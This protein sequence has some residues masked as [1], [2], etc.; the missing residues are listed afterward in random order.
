MY[1]LIE[2]VFYLFLFERLNPP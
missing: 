2:C 1:V